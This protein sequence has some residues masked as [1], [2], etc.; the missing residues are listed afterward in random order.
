MSPI[1]KKELVTLTE[2][3]TKIEHLEEIAKELKQDLTQLRKE[4]KEDQQR[5][6]DRRLTIY[7]ALSSILGATILKIIEW[8]LSLRT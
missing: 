3:R 2:C 8:L 7:L 4:R 5:I 6:S 1:S